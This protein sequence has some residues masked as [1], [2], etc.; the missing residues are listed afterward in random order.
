MKKRT[1]KRRPSVPLMLFWNKR[2]QLRFIDAVEKLCSQCNDLAMLIGFLEDVAK[3]LSAKKPRT[4]KA[5]P[6]A[7]QA[8]NGEG[9][10]A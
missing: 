1:K 8:V 5:A 2:D 6:I 4:R 7:D 3:A 10:A 9:G